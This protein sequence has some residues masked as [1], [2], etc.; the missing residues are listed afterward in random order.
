MRLIFIALFIYL[1]HG[2]ASAQQF[3]V[4]S[5]APGNLVLNCCDIFGSDF[6]FLNYFKQTNSFKVNPATTAFQQE[7][8]ANMY[9]ADT[10][11]L[12]VTYA[13]VT[14]LPPDYYNYDWNLAWDGTCG[15]SSGAPGMRFGLTG[16]ITPRFTVSG[17]GSFV[18]ASNSTLDTFGA[19]GLI[20]LRFTNEG[21]ASPAVTPSFVAGA[22]FAGCTNVRLYKASTASLV[23]AGQIF[24]PDFINKLIALNA[25]ILRTG[26]WNAM[27]GFVTSTVLEPPVD[28]FSYMN[29]YWNSALWAG[30]ITCS[31]S[32]GTD[33]YSATLAGATLTDGQT[34]QGHFAAANTGTAPTLSIN[35]GANVPIVELDANAPTVGLIVANSSATLIYDAT[36]NEWLTSSSGQFSTPSQ[37]VPLSI[38][39]Q[40]ANAINANLWYNCWPHT[41]DNC[42]SE[43]NELRPVLNHGFYPELGDE[44]WN[45]AQA[46]TGWATQRGVALGFTASNNRQVFGFYGLRVR[47][48]MA[49][50]KTLWGS[51]TLHPVIANWSAFPSQSNTY[52]LQGTDLCGTTCGNAS[53][54]SLV[55]VDYNSAP[56]R[57]IDFIT[58]NGVISYATYTN[59]AVLSGSNY[60]GTYATADLAACSVAGTNSGGLQCM[61]DN[62]QL[63]TGAAIAAAFAW[64]DNDVRQGT[65]NSTL[66]NATLLAF[67][68]ASTGVYALWNTI[69][70]SYSVPIAAYEGGFQDIAPTVLQCQASPINGVNA[71]LGTNAATYCGPTGSIQVAL[72]AYKFSSSLQATQLLQFQQFVA[73]SPANSIP[74]WF[75]FCENGVQW[76]LCDTGLYGNYYTSY[77]AIQAF[78]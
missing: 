46:I 43:V 23:A 41:N 52:R 40:L 67:S 14:P 77:N 51:G 26:D 65:K 59:G 30:T 9:P 75:T 37:I 17:G 32:A 69:A 64:I 70:A 36:L 53:Y 61:A 39:A 33:T 29:G 47:Q 27:N 74:S 42:T 13:G 7:I 63:G 10:A 57:P 56:N 5:L 11:S 31:C 2:P 12:G 50:I 28:S 6:A 66:G 18:S 73:G 60:T 16:S 8:N 3:Y 4:S 76:S 62:Y 38:Q 15:S 54:Q 20:T 22:A 45:P 72:T 71:S 48:V 58:P 25:N 44:W 49:N 35:G 78:N 21:V 34:I 68:T 19:A 24:N 55:G 1:I